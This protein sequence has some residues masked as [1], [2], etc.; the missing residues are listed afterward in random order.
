MPTV[1]IRSFQ[2]AIV[3]SKLSAQNKASKGEGSDFSPASQADHNTTVI[4]SASDQIGTSPS[5][6]RLS[7]NIT[8]RPPN[9]SMSLSTWIA[10]KPVLNSFNV[11]MNINNFI[12]ISMEL[13]SIECHLI[14]VSSLSRNRML[15]HY[16]SVT[17]TD[18]CVLNGGFCESVWQEDIWEVPKCSVNKNT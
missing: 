3:S 9:T 5:L 6:F 8:F 11:R 14:G 16:S 15:F 7:P 2:F 13:I 18:L 4:T 17:S 12:V 1:L 10:V